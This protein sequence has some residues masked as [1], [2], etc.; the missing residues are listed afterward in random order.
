MVKL[1]TRIEDSSGKAHC[2]DCGQKIP[3]GTK[4]LVL[5]SYQAEKKV[6]PNCVHKYDGIINPITV[7]HQKLFELVLSKV[8]AMY[9]EKT[10]NELFV[11]DIAKTYSGMSPDEIATM[12]MK[13][14]HDM[15]IVV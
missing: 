4:S 3:A 7:V 9:E 14:Y 8:N 10:G 2:A 1:H 15:N 6:C 5:I 12:I 11:G 13:E